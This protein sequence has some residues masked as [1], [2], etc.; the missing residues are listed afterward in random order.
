MSMTDQ[1]PERIEN[2][3]VVSVTMSHKYDF[4][5][6]EGGI[7]DGQ[8]IEDVANSLAVEKATDELREWPGAFV[9]IDDIEDVE[10]DA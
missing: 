1:E 8:T 2:R 5:I 10:D 4:H 3:V 7:P 9:T 6:T